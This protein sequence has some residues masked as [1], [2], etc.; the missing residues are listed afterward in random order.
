M[1]CRVVVMLVKWCVWKVRGRRGIQLFGWEGA[2]AGNMLG[3][4]LDGGGGI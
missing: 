4:L 3:C 1:A 2:L